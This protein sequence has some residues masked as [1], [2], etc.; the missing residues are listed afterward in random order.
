MCDWGE[1]KDCS[2]STED[3]NEAVVIEKI[4]EKRDSTQNPL[5]SISVSATCCWACGFQY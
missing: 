4:H 5:I 1:D 2:E 3:R